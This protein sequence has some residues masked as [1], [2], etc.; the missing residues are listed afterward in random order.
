MLVL[1]ALAITLWA[2]HFTRIE[3]EFPESHIDGLLVCTPENNVSPGGFSEEEWESIG[4]EFTNALAESLLESEDPEA[5]LLG[6][7]NFS[8]SNEPLK[9]TQI[10]KLASEHPDNALINL[11]L[12]NACTQYTDHPGCSASSIESA[13]A[14]NADNAVSW[15]LLAVYRKKIQDEFGADRAMLRAASAPKFEDYFGKQV[16]IMRDAILQGPDY[17][18]WWSTW[19]ILARSTLILQNTHFVSSVCD[20]SDSLRLSLLE[21]CQQFGERMQAERQSLMAIAVGGGIQQAAFA[22]MGNSTEA[23]R[24]EREYMTR[25]SNRSNRES[26]WAEWDRTGSLMMYD[27]DLTLYWLDSIVEYGETETAILR[28]VEE[29]KRLSS[30]PEYKPCRPPRPILHYI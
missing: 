6:I 14:V 8:T 20:V 15:S 9:I 26:T 28:V 10:A 11:R 12:L 18:Y 3:I 24:V 17:Q 16:G 25:Q 22:A 23:R 1:S 21:A 7:Q 13:H 29:A 5:R 30:D 19:D 2:Y 27:V 4:S